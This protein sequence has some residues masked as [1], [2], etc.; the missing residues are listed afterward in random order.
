MDSY[1][2]EQE[3]RKNTLMMNSAKLTLKSGYRPI[4]NNGVLGNGTNLSHH[5]RN[6]PANKYKINQNKY[7]NR[8]N[9][10]DSLS[11]T[12]QKTIMKNQGIVNATADEA[13]IP[14]AINSTARKRD[15]AK[16]AQ[17]N[18]MQNFNNNK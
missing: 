9:Q 8:T 2:K 4:N 18:L 7:Q 15:S 17:T 14:Q 3:R 13:K 11:S 5:Q 10:T 16:R 12:F 1:Y 6:T